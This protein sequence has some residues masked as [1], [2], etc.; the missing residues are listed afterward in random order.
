FLDH[1]ENDF[2]AIDNKTDNAIAFVDQLYKRWIDRK[3]VD[4]PI[5]YKGTV[6]ISYYHK[7]E[8][9]AE[10]LKDSLEREGIRVWFD[11]ESLKAGKHIDKIKKAIA[12]AECKIFV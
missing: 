4:K 5:Q 9:D 12:D 6:F 8:K 10:N 7:Y 3:K 11:R 2:I 1:C